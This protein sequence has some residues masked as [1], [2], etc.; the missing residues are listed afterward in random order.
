MPKQEQARKIVLKW[1]ITDCENKI[2]LEQIRQLLPGE[3]K[4]SGFKCL[5]VYAL[6]G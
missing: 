4:I 3:E 6:F 5:I 2:K 1:P